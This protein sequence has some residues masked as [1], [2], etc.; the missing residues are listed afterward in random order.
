MRLPLPAD[1]LDRP[2]PR[3]RATGRGRPAR[4]S[5]A[6]RGALVDG[7]DRAAHD[8]ARDLAADRVVDRRRLGALLRRRADTGDAA[9][10]LSGSARGLHRDPDADRDDLPPRRPHARAGLHLHVSLAPYP[11]RAHRRTRLQY[12]LPGRSWGASG[13]GQ[14]GR[15]AARRRPTR[16][17]LRRLLRMRHRLPSG[18]RHP[19]WPADGLH[20]VRPVR[21]RLRHRHGQARPAG[22]PDRLRHRGQPPEPGRRQGPRQPRRPSAHRPVRGPRRGHRR[23]HA[24]QPRD[25][26]LHGPERPARPQPAV[27]DTLRRLDPQRLHGP[28][29]QQA[30]RRA[31]L[32]AGSR[33]SAR[34]AGRGRRRLGRRPAGAVQC[35]TRVPRPRLRTAW[36][37]ADRLRPP[38][39]PN[40]R[41]CHRRDGSCARQLQ[42]PMTMPTIASPRPPHPSGRLTGRKVL[43][44][45]VAFFGTVASADAFLVTSAFRT[46][47]GLDEPS[48]YQA[49]QRYNAELRRAAEQE[50]LGWRL[51]ATA[52]RNPAAVASIN[53]TVADDGGRP[54]RGQSLRARLERPT[55][56]RQDLSVELNEVG[57]GTYEAR[58]EPVARGQWDLVVEAVGPKGVAFRRRH[59]IVLD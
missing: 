11:S 47:S 5:E 16:R 13:L 17:R 45:F 42:G 48:P 22:R 44:I 37:R 31:T 8:E 3:C 32:R 15:R 38:D 35:D 57:A 39:F 58:A 25:A 20:P 40:R 34:G 55:D 24:L 49:S 46:W 26:Q 21:R 28:A 19:R 7:E 30:P 2:V 12:P 54:V 56:K 1:R 53:V 4:A 27:R 41:R 59:R 36:R 23:L 10:D 50:V 18:H 9:G 33:R 29:Q 14:A 51:D 52:V 43:M 6:R